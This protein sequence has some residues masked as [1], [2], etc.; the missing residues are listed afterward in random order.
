VT[1]V[2]WGLKAKGSALHN[3]LSVFWGTP[4]SLA[5]QVPGGRFPLLDRLDLLEHGY[6]L[7]GADARSGLV[8]PGRD[9]LIVAG[10]LFALEY[11]A[12][13]VVEPPHEGPVQALGHLHRTRVLYR[14]AKHVLFPVRS[15]FTTG[16]D[17]T[18]KI[19]RPQLLL[20]QGLREL[21]KLVLF[22]VRFLFTT[23][24]GR[25]G[26]NEDAVNHYL[27]ADTL[28]GAV[29]VAAALDWRTAPPESDEAVLSLLE[30][31]MVPLYLHY[32]DNQRA[33]LAALGRHDLAEAFGQWRGRLLQ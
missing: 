11:L 24:T 29:L 27:A 21:T 4:S 20:A 33:H 7:W 26:T 17:P 23:E 2:A 16:K 18:E 1:A 10:A 15:I 13:L 25:V 8:P 30:S 12:G 6:L 31:E 3:R 14:L 22:P 32:I 9:E 19:R 28:P 5:G